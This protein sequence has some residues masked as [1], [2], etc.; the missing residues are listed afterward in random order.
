MNDFGF[1]NN[2]SMETDDFMNNQVLNQ[3]TNFLIQDGVARQLV[4]V[5][6]AS[7]HKNNSVGVE[8]AQDRTLMT[9]KGVIRNYE[10]EHKALVDSIKNLGL[11]HF[12]NDAINEKGDMSEAEAVKTFANDLK[13][14]FDKNCRYGTLEERYNFDKADEKDKITKG[15]NG[16][17]YKNGSEINSLLANIAT[18]IHPVA[19]NERFIVRNEA[20]NNNKDTEKAEGDNSEEVK[21][22][23]DTSIEQTNNK[24]EI[25]K[26]EK[27]KERTCLVLETCENGEWKET[28]VIYSESWNEKLESNSNNEKNDS[29]ITGILTKIT[30]K[31]VNEFKEKFDAFNN[32][33]KKTERL[34]EKLDKA[35]DR[36]E[37][38]STFSGARISKYRASVNTMKYC[39]RLNIPY[40]GKYLSKGDMLLASIRCATNINAG[41]LFTEK[42]IMKFV[43]RMTVEEKKEFQKDG[44]TKEERLK[45]NADNEKIETVDPDKIDVSVEKINDNAKDDTK[46]N[47]K[48]DVTNDT[49]NE[50]KGNSK[51]AEKDENDIKFEIG[52]ITVDKD[53]LARRVY[54]KESKTFKDVLK[55]NSNGEFYQTLKDEEYKK[56]K[57]YGVNISNNV[58]GFYRDVDDEK[59]FAISENGQMLI[60][61]DLPAKDNPLTI[62]DKDKYTAG[63]FIVKD[64]KGTYLCDT[65]LLVKATLDGEPKD[66][67]EKIEIDTKK[68]GNIGKFIDSVDG[69]IKNNDLGKINAKDD[70]FGKAVDKMY[71]SCKDE[72]SKKRENLEAQK[73][74][75]E[76]ALDTI[77]NMP[78]NKKDEKIKG[79]TE[80]LEDIKD[81]IDKKFEGAKDKEVSFDGKI[82]YI[83]NF[84]DD[85][86]KIEIDKDTQDKIDKQRSKDI[87]EKIKNG[88]IDEKIE[89]LNEKFKLDCDKTDK[90]DTLDDVGK[91]NTKENYLK[92]TNDKIKEL[93]KERDDNKDLE[94]TK[95]SKDNVEVEKAVD[96]IATRHESDP[97]KPSILGDAIKEFAKFDI[98]L[99]EN[100]KNIAKDVE[101][102]I[103]KYESTY[104]TYGVTKGDDYKKEFVNLAKDKMEEIIKNETN[105]KEIAKDVKNTIDIY[106]KLCNTYKLGV[107]DGFKE[108]FEKLAFDKYKDDT[109]EFKGIVK[110]YVTMGIEKETRPKN[111]EKDVNEATKKYEKLCETYEV[112]KGENYKNDIIGTMKDKVDN[113][114][115]LKK[116][117]GMLE[118]QDPV[119]KGE[120]K[121]EI[122]EQGS[123]TKP[124]QSGDTLKLELP[125]CKSELGKDIASAVEEGDTRKLQEIIFDGKIDELMPEENELKDTFIGFARGDIELS[126]EEKVELIKNIDDKAVEVENKPSEEVYVKAEVDGGEKFVDKKLLDEIPDYENVIEEVADGSTNDNFYENFLTP[127]ELKALEAQQNENA[128]DFSEE[129]VAIPVDEKTGAGTTSEEAPISYRDEITEKGQGKDFEEKAK[130]YFKNN[131]KEMSP[132]EII[133][134]ARAVSTELRS[135][136]QAIEIMDK[137]LIDRKDVSNPERVDVFS[138]IADDIENNV[139]KY[140]PDIEINENEISIE[141]KG[142]KI[143]VDLNNDDKIE[144]A[145]NSIIE[146][147]CGAFVS[148]DEIKGKL[149]EAIKDI[150]LG[151]KGEIYDNLKKALTNLVAPVAIDCIRGNV[152]RTEN[153][154]DACVKAKEFKDIDNENENK[155]DIEQNE[156]TENFENYEDDVGIGEW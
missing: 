17:Y 72:V 73:T 128:N 147:C 34:V 40:N 155:Q 30:E 111:V 109:T 82:A 11:E 18:W 95:K 85:N 110:E 100:P 10:T 2:F 56:V 64:E 79:L 53:M 74:K 150:G 148:N 83:Q 93:E 84:K 19:E 91:E 24:E 59:S 130:D 39:Y 136:A 12:L 80:K 65:T 97:E 15:E 115:V 4:Q 87:D 22:N 63:A 113:D 119:E 71:N 54:D 106:G 96:R 99:E 131:Y 27:N 42:M 89:A 124:E 125:D 67:N 140:L 35:I 8:K 48:D 137:A 5:G 76:K 1:D 90:N 151:D 81:S 75:I 36:Q 78:D 114:K 61:V 116:L 142:G 152:E 103:N 154:I 45:V 101:N 141:T 92:E 28:E 16:K 132:D 47:I 123:V 52:G 51:D 86:P 105:P 126:N 108:N 94:I 143:T 46:D 138:K 146:A 26:N 58:V 104:N 60:K 31:S 117:D 3:N 32:V 29:E 69:K 122:P 20:D 156:D 153:R 144:N 9:D 149:V 62:N 120:S 43:D 25:D 77:K 66:K 68:L 14:F 102:A 112:D 13:D 133:N 6:E 127:D 41:G 145:V 23:N 57:E 135:P 118:K 37:Y 55:P 33:Y 139:E 7:M 21:Q 38:L 50:V 44:L 98:R 121:S 49:K 107:E 88:T 134:F 129:T 70:A